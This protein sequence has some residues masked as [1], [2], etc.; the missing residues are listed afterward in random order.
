MDVKG[1]EGV[2]KACKETEEATTGRT[3]SEK[4][5]LLECGRGN[6]GRNVA[7]KRVELEGEERG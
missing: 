1:K 3:R 4:S 5:N 7:K 2:G 6:G